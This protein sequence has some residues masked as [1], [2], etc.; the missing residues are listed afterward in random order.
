MNSNLISLVR[1][2]FSDLLFN[3]QWLIF[4]KNNKI[5]AN[6]REKWVPLP[7]ELDDLTWILVILTDFCISAPSTVRGHRNC[8]TGVNKQWLNFE[9]GNFVSLRSILRQTECFD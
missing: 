2:Y 4:K 3:E 7:G 5:Q 6:G 9:A 8:A 1:E